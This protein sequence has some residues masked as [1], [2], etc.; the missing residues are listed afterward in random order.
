MNTTSMTL[1]KLDRDTIVK[2]RDTLRLKGIYVRK[3][4]GIKIALALSERLTIDS[5]WPNE[6]PQRSLQRQMRPSTILTKTF[7]QF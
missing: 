4:A 1:N 6:D 2:L 5:K 7:N 3:G